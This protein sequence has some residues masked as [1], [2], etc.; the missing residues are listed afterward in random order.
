MTVAKGSRVAKPRQP[1]LGSPVVPQLRWLWLD[2]QRLEGWSPRVANLLPFAT[3][4]HVTS[5]INKFTA[6][7]SQVED[8]NRDV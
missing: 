3:M 5:V 4:T 8:N 6:T 7:A 1:K 2:A